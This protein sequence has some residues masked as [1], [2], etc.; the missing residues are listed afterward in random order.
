MK[1][2]AIS[3][4]NVDEVPY[5]VSDMSEDVKR[6]VEFYNEWRQKESDIKSELMLVQAGQRDLSREIITTI[7]REKEAAEVA[8]AAVEAAKAEATAANDAADA[9]EGEIVD[10]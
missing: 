9:T 8:K 6:L 4:I 2:E 7:R 3:I 5:A 1:V 10:A